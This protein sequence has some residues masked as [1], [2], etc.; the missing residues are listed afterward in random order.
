VAICPV[1]HIRSKREYS[2]NSLNIS[3]RSVISALNKRRTPAD[4]YHIHREG[5]EERGEKNKK[6]II[7]ERRLKSKTV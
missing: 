5:R 3:V 6:G 7:M 1:S 2:D 4:I